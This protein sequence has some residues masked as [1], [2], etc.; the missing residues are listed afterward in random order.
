M[1]IEQRELNKTTHTC[2]GHNCWDH[3]DPLPALAESAL[4]KLS[5]L[6]TDASGRTDAAFSSD[7]HNAK[8]IGA[9]ELMMGIIDHSAFR[10]VP[11]EYRGPLLEAMEEVRASLKL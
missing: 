5:S 6:R 1:N 7:T 10:A 3:A 11:P 9:G 8:A 4:S 2:D